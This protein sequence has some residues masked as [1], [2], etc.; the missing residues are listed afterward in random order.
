MIC[1]ITAKNERRVSKS[2]H[3]ANIIDNKEKKY[4]LIINNK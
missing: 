3:G 1:I 4:N 2:V